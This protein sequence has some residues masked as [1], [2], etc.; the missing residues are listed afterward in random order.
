[1][2]S[3]ATTTE[4]SASIAAVPVVEAASVGSRPTSARVLVSL[5]STLSP[6]APEVLLPAPALTVS[7]KKSS[8]EVASTTTLPPAVTVVAAPLRVAISASVVS[9]STVTSRPMPTP[10]PL[11]CPEPM[12]TAMLPAKSMTFT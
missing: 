7:W 1:M 2:L 11:F 9:L 12:V 5:T 6:P 10:L 3:A 4:P 8:D